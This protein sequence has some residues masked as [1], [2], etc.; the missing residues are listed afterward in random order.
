MAGNLRNLPWREL[1]V[2]FLGQLL[3]L[4]RQPVDL[5]GNEPG[6]FVFVLRGVADD[7]GSAALGRPELLVPTTRIL[8]DHGVGRRENVLSGA[9]ILLQKN[10]AGGREISLEIGDVANVC[11]AERI[12]GLIRIAH[13]RQLGGGQTGEQVLDGD[14]VLPVLGE[15]GQVIGDQVLPFDDA[16]VPERFLRLAPVGGWSC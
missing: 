16:Q 4:P 11:P 14:L 3:A 2:D 6:F 15:A 5:F 12:N 7:G 9:V 10:G 1:G 8:R 13:D